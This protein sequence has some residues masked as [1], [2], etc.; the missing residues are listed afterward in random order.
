MTALTFTEFRIW[1]VVVPARQDI[2]GA[3]PPQ[4][5]IYREGLTWPEI[6]IHLVEGVTSEGFTA[7]GRGRPGSSAGNGRRDVARSPRT[8]SAGD[9]AVDRLDADQGAQ[10]FATELPGLVVGGSRR[11]ALLPARVTVVRRDGQASGLPAHRLMGGAVRDVV[12]ADYWA[13]RPTAKTLAKLVTEAQELGLKGIK[14][15]CDSQGDMVNAVLEIAGDVD[16]GFRFTIDPM[17]AWRSFRESAR[18][19]RE[20][21]EDR[22]AGAD[23]GSL[24]NHSGGRLATRPKQVGPM[25]LVVHPRGT[26]AFPA[27]AAGGTGR[28]LQPGRRVGDRVS[29]HFDRR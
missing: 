23:R 15:K 1:Q 2:I 25:T 18:F 19:L 22:A 3:S 9:V 5:S 13:N 20:A 14:M 10:R 8:Q 7:V 4:G 17:Y 29:A 12:P 16:P 24:S 21:G 26:G 27:G 6:P 28:C 11:P